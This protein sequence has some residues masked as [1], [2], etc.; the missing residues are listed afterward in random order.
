MLVSELGRGVAIATVALTV[1]LGRAMVP[2]LIAVAVVEGVLEVFSGLAERRYVGSLVEHSQVSSALVSIETRTHLVLVAGRPLGGLLFEISPI[3]PFAADVLS[4]IYS[5]LTLNK[6]E[7]GQKQLEKIAGQFREASLRNS[8]KNDMT[9]GLRR[10]RKDTFAL[11]TI[12]SF[13]IGTLI[14]QALIMVFLGDANS[15]RLSDFAIGLVLAA[16]GIGGAI[17]S[18]LASRIPG[19]ASR[20]WVRVQ[21]LIWSAGFIVFIFPFGR[22]F[23]ISAIVMAILGFSG[24]LG[25][26]AL[27]SHLMQEGNKEMLARVTSVSRLATVSACSIGPVLGGV[28]V[29][30]L[31]VRFAMLCLFLFTPVL[32]LLS[33]R[34]P[35]ASS[36][37]EGVLTGLV[38]YRQE[39]KAPAG[40]K[41][42]RLAL[43]SAP[44]HQADP[45][46]ALIEARDLVDAVEIRL[47]D[48]DVLGV[49]RAHRL[50]SRSRRA[51]L[52]G[53]RPR[54]VGLADG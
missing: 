42:A 20:S 36:A 14:F 4:F 53:G 9:Q 11:R 38:I 5:V 1:A 45:D 47:T 41:S 33:F 17:G 32:I 44:R 26:I 34:T 16:S 37:K 30:E 52:R 43:T 10:I 35:V 29:Q 31:G 28:L 8:L 49:R 12:T 22:N 48:A 6:I 51:H 7:D 25:N 54:Q 39:E 21:T 2:F 19:A 3:F 18:A 50:P 23:L 13:S 27:N 24:A 46:W 40:N 15:Q